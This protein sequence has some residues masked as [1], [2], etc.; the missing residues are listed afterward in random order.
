MQIPESRVKYYQQ[1]QLFGEQ[2]DKKFKALRGEIAEA[3]KCFAAGRDT[4]TVFHLMRVMEV[5]VQRLGKKLG[6]PDTK[7]KEWQIILNSVNGAVNKGSV[8]DFV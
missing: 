6:V 8:K 5:G 7:E 2:V 3:G 4:A 1:A